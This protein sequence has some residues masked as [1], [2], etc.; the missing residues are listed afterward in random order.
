LEFLKNMRKK[1]IC[2]LALLVLSLSFFPLF[3]ATKAQ[4]STPTVSLVASTT[5]ATQLNQ[6]ITVN[7]TISNVQD[8]WSWAGNLTWDPT[9]LQMVGDPAEG[10][11]MQPQVGN[12]LFPPLY[13]DNVDGQIIGI[14]DTVEKNEGANGTGFLATMQFQVISQTSSTTIQLSG[15]VLETPLPADELAHTYPHPQI[16]PTSALA[17]TTITFVSGGAPAA[18]AGPAQ[19]VKVGATVTFNGAASLSS[20]TNPTY[21]WNFTDNNAT[22]TLAGVNPTYTF[23]NPGIFVVTLWLQD[24]N[25]V[26]N[27]TVTITVNGPPPVAVIT[28]EGNPKSV[29]VGQPITFVSSNSTGSIVRWLWDMGDALGTGTNSSITYTYNSAG[30]YNVTLTVFDATNQNS[31]TLTEITATGSAPAGTPGPTTNATPTPAG[32][33]TPQATQTSQA[34]PDSTS[35]ANTLADAG[36]PAAVLAL[37]TVI[38]LVV[39]GGS[40]FWLRKRT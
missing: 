35:G 34:T 29:A 32:S 19:I 17:S 6:I 23:N 13:P 20:G 16:T 14:S 18:N 12:T 7:I 3:G 2:L 21:T 15:I 25:G 39:L 9:C 27:S 24:S 10:N 5:Q 26:G 31:T 37:L 40:V 11:F 1:K 38:T 36:L 30:I 8:L 22:Q 4:S 33:S 28:V